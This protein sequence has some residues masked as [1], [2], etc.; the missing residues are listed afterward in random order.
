MT[1]QR[2]PE[3]LLEFVKARKEFVL[4]DG[5]INRLTGKRRLLRA[6]DDVSLTVRR[7]EIVG[8]VGESGSGKSTLAQA[9]V[10]LLTVDEGYVNYRGENLATARGRALKDFRRSVQMV[11]QDTGS[12]LNPRKTVGRALDES[13]ALRGLA[14]ARRTERSNELLDVVGLNGALRQRYPHQL[15]G[16]QRQRVAIARCLALEPEFLVADEPVASLDVSLQSQIIKLLLKLRNELGLTLLFISHDLALVS[17]ISTRVAVM[18]GGRIVEE[19]P[20]ETVLRS[21][22]DPYTRAL[23]AAIP[24]G[25]KG[26][27]ARRESALL[28][29]SAPKEA[30]E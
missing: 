9:A 12:S 6:L 5:L 28:A 27:R 22:S 23:L 4:D 11:F 18:H 1:S 7:G 24:K 15:S 17:H 16:G 25:I 19:G 3:I 8:L 30:A 2:E 13:L 29:V 26:R 21:P 10:R 14:R 20:P